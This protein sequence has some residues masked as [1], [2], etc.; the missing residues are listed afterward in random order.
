MPEV[1]NLHYLIPNNVFMMTMAVFL[2]QWGFNSYFYNSQ[3]LVKTLVNILSYYIG[4]KFISVII[5][6]RFNVPH[7]APLYDFSSFW[8]NNFIFS[9][10]VVIMGQEFFLY[11]GHLACHKHPLLWAIHEPHH[12]V[13]ELNLSTS[14]LTGWFMP[15]VY[16]VSTAPMILLLSVLNMDWKIL[17]IPGHAAFAIY[18]ILI[19]SGSIY[20]SKTFSKILILPGDHALHHEIESTS[21]NSNYGSCLSIYDHL[22]GTYNGLPNIEK[23]GCLNQRNDL[24]ILRVQ[25]GPFARAWALLKNCPTNKA[26]VQLFFTGR[27]PE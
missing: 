20:K 5:L 2:I 10:F 11:I 27:V 25:L 23:Y 17:F 6:R 18:Q 9:V 7:L 21:Q 22:F 4:L 24:N 15:L 14:L 8:N 13:T 12:S 26:R 16:A 3:S 1:P 19:H